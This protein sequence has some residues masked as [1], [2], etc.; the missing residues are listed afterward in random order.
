MSSSKDSLYG[1]IIRTTTVLLLLSGSL[2]NED[3]YVNDAKATCYKTQETY[4]CLK[5]R[6]LR[7]ISTVVGDDSWTR[8]INT[9]N[10]YDEK[11]IKLVHMKDYRQWGASPENVSGYFEET[12]QLRGDSE[13]DRFVKFGK[14]QIESFLKSYGLNIGL[15]DGAVAISQPALDG[16]FVFCF[17]F[18]A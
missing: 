14:R 15:P 1:T 13:V 18:R 3:E 9:T 11:P 17:S 7:Y 6:T 16:E 4:S 2:A 10:Q 8:S 12:R 5:Y